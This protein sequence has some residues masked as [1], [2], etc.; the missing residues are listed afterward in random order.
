MNLLR[1]VSCTPSTASIKEQMDD[2]YGR[3]HASGLHSTGRIILNLWRIMR[4]V[5]EGGVE[6]YER[7]G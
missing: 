5:G 7:C 6:D 2:E 1:M 3:L 4:G